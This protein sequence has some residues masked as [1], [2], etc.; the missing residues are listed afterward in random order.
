MRER[1]IQKEGKERRFVE[2]KRDIGIISKRSLLCEFSHSG[3]FILY[4]SLS[5][6]NLWSNF[7]GKYLSFCY[8][9]SVHFT[10]RATLIITFS[11]FYEHSSPIFKRLNIIKLSDLVFLN[12]GVLSH[13]FYIDIYLLILSSL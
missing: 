9:S 10:K 2:I 1:L 3:Q 5:L 7:L 11:N 8:S 4:L 6:F 12:I 13:K